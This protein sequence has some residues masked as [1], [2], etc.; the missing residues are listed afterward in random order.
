MSKSDTSKLKVTQVSLNIRT[1]DRIVNNVLNDHVPFAKK[2]VRAND[3]SFMTKSLR[4]AIM[5]IITLR[6]NKLRTDEK[7]K[8]LKKQR[9]KCIN[10]LQEAETS[11]S[12]KLLTD[13][14]E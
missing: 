3:S 2:T 5:T 4:K 14:R 6:Y 10:L 12:V 8:A 7:W 9:N 11:F 13:S 1:F